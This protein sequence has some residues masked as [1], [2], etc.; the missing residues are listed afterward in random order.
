MSDQT[1]NPNKLF[2][3][4]LPFSVTSEQLQEL[5]APYGELVSAE[6][7]TERHTGRS[8]GIGFV[9][10]TTLEA[11][12]AAKEALNN[13]EVEGR[14]IFVATARP[15]KPRTER[16]FDG[17]D[18]GYGQGGGYRSNDRGHGGNR[19]NFQRRSGDR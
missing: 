17:G 11:A 6:V 7:V 5:F 2:V 10:Y 8:R 3:G 18:R 15:P 9:E 19:Q 12:E 14:T 1:A 16:S 13:T 4:N